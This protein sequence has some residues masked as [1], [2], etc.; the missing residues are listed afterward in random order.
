MYLIIILVQ[1][2]ELVKCLRD[3][4]LGP[5]FVYKQLFVL[6][7]LSYLSL[8]PVDDDLCFVIGGETDPGRGRIGDVLLE[9]ADLERRKDG[10]VIAGHDVRRAPV[11]RIDDARARVGPPQD[12][13]AVRGNV[14]TNLISSKDI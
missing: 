8:T 14:D 5:N 7:F 4:S 2:K 11:G 6:Y 3:T 1:L 13:I 10:G 12:S 9:A